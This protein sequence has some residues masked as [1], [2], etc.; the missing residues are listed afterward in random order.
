MPLDLARWAL[1]LLQSLRMHTCLCLI[2]SSS[3]SSES[4]DESD[5]EVENLVMPLDPI[6]EVRN[7]DPD[8]DM[9]Q[10]CKSQIVHVR[11]VGSPQ[12]SFSCGV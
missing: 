12:S 1:K 11:A 6:A 10:H 4:N 8:F 2:H 7:W 9:Y 3:S 5:T